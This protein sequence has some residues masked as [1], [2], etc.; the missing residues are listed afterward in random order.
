MWMNVQYGIVRRLEQQ[1]YVL[2]DADK[3]DVKD[4]YFWE[5]LRINS[6]EALW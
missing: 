5:R 1:K 6:W 2:M 4:L 3:S